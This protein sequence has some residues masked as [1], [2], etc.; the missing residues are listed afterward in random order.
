VNDL[1]SDGEPG[2]RV[3][4]GKI[5]RSAATGVEYKY[6]ISTNVSGLG[7]LDPKLRIDN[8]SFATDNTYGREG[9]PEEPEE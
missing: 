2:I 9:P 7:P 8:G 6:T 3:I 4:R 5:Q 1:S